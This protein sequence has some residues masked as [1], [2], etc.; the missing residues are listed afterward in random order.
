MRMTSRPWRRMR[1]TAVLGG[2]TVVAPLAAL[3]VAPAATASAATSVLPCTTR[4]TTTP[5]TQWGDTN[6]YFT[7]PGGTFE[8]G[9][10]G[11]TLSGGAGVTGGNE[12][13]KV[14]SGPNT[15]SLNLPAGAAATAPSLCIATAEDSM[16]LFYKSPGVSTAYLRV[17]IHVTS[18]VNVADNTYDINGAASGW[19]VSQRIMLP[20]IRDK[21][22][23]QTVTVSFTQVGTRAAWQ[24][25][26][27]EID[28]WR[29]L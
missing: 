3:L 12:P 4:S 24:V 22:G 5:F 27:V 15:S 29:S 18:G 14:I 23:Q 21:S 1:R 9:T 13:W 17:T 25:D 6:S 16:R 19:A 26:D 7:L 2:L 20:D 28:P 10:A 8:T 11:W